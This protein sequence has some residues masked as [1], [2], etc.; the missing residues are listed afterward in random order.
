MGRAQIHYEVFVRRT[1]QARWRLDCA[2]EDRAQA[3]ETAESL[4]REGRAVGVRVN[5]EV[6]DAETGGYHS[7]VIL[8]KGLTQ[9]EKP[10]P[11]RE[12][13]EPPC[14]T[15]AD[16]YTSHA[17]EKI[18]RLFEDW[19][20]RR[21]VTAFELL[22]RPDLAEILEA[23]GVELLHAVQKI[24]VPESQATGAPLHDL[25]RS[26]QKLSEAALARLIGAGRKR[27]FPNLAK[28]SLG[29]VAARLA[30]MGDRQFLLGG[31]VAQ[32]LADAPDWGVKIERLLKFAEHLPEAAQPRAL[33]HVVLEQLLAEILGGRGAMTALLG[34]DLD[35]GAS[36]LALARLVAPSEVEALIRSDAS[37]ATLVPTMTPSAGR[38]A[39]LMRA[40]AFTLLRGVL[41]RRVLTELTSPKRLRPADA[42]GEIAVLRVLAMALTASA[43]RLLSLEEVQGA[44]LERSKAIVSGEFV[45]A[46]TRDRATVLEEAQALIRLIENVTGPL[47]RTR[48]AEWLSTCV[49]SLR[50]EKECRTG[51]PE[52]AV[53]RLSSL[54]ALERSVRRTG[55]ADAD[56]RHI[57]ARLGD[58]AGLIEADAKLCALLARSPAPLP[59]KATL[60]LRIAAGDLCPAGPAADRARATLMRL[61]KVPGALSQLAGSPDVTSR[62]REMMAA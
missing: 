36:L 6:Q 25:I 57:C 27:L 11:V 9:R 33:C 50:F 26:Y 28:E 3:L 29:E 38:L 43:G 62:L 61:L 21:K 12:S 18:G 20:R 60:L 53:A 34:D 56:Q 5:K 30:E 40:D 4:L 55:L 24:A 32:F 47:N 31:A 46:L 51:G 19:L 54:A 1:S 14:I 59:Q 2:L 23:S 58:I 42:D 41:A 48:A 22:H 17:R 10:K 8:T 15:P 37:A 13:N 44:F 49:D 7:Y 35:T 39:K 52:S 16:L 45:S